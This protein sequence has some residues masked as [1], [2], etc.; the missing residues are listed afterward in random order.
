[1]KTYIG[2]QAEHH[3]MQTFQEELIELL[4][5]AGVDFDPKY[6]D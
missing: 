6:L 4:Q 3:R 5:K 2:R 1:V